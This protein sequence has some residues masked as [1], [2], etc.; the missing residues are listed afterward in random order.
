MRAE[1]YSILIAVYFSKC[2]KNDL[3]YMQI[4]P[5][6]KPN[7]TTIKKEKYFLVTAK[8]SL[9]NWNILTL[10]KPNVLI[11]MDCPK[12]KDIVIIW[13]RTFFEFNS[14]MPT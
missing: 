6:Y 2:K 9:I 11:Y 7:T 1:L 14:Q 3:R 12:V 13:D 10:Q 5:Q 4:I 8:Y